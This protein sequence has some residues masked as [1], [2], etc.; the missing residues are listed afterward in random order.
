[1]YARIARHWGLMNAMAGRAGVDLGMEYLDGSI[2]RETLRSA[3]FRCA[4]CGHVSACEAHLAR[5]GGPHD[6][7]PDYCL[8][9]TLID[10][11]RPVEA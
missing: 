11:L 1:M 7:V 10:R 2:A 3:V 8:N 9:R 6:E 5:A 4:E